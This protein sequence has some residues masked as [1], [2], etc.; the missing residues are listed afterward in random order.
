MISKSNS[1]KFINYPNCINWNLT[2]NPVKP[3]IY[4]FIFLNMSRPFSQLM[5]TDHPEKKKFSISSFFEDP[6]KIKKI[7]PPEGGLFFGTVN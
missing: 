2:D 7:S 1:Q 6:R 4:D 5:L 3:E